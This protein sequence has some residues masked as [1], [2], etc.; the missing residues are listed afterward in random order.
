MALGAFLATTGRPAEARPENACQLLPVVLDV[1][2]SGTRYQTEISFTNPDREAQEMAVR[3]TASLGLVEGDGD[4]RFSV[5]PGGQLFVRDGIEFLRQLGVAIQ[6]STAGTPQAGTLRICSLNPGALPVGVMAR[7]TSPTRPPFAAGKAGVAFAAVPA[8][9]GFAGRAIVFGFR[10]NA[11]ERSNVAIYNPGAEPV[12][13]SVTL[14]SGSGERRSVISAKEDL[15]GYAWKQFTN[16]S[17]GTPVIDQGYVV[18][19]RIS[20]GGFFGAY[21]VVNDNDTN[22]GSFIPAAAEGELRTSWTIPVLVDSPSYRSELILANP[23]DVDATFSLV[24]MDSVTRS[25]LPRSA[26]VPVAA[27]RQVIVPDVFDLF[28]AGPL[29][30]GTVTSAGTLRVRTLEEEIRGAFVG[31]RVLTREEGGRFGVFAP[32][33]PPESA[34]AD[35]GFLWGLRADADTR[36]NVAVLNASS[37]SGE[38]ITLQ[39]QVF[40]GATGRPAGAPLAVTLAPGQWAQPEG[41]FASSGA[42]NGDVRIVRV[43]GSGPWSAYGVVNDGAAPG[44]GTGDG[45]FVP[46]VFF[47]GAPNRLPEGAWGAEGVRMWVDATGVNIE[48]DCSHGSLLGP[49]FLDAQGRFSG[50]GTYALEGGPTPVGGFPA[51]NVLYS[52]QVERGQMTLTIS[53][54]LLPVSAQMRLVAIQGVSPQLHK[55]L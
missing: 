36:S 29:P 16:P 20:A 6:G 49:V 48:T 4:G 35:Q 23:G 53:F 33:V 15:A 10:R 9:E 44:E 5:P 43:S 25:G 13:V 17:V 51:H 27:H 39:L 54:P 30:G 3:Y 31:V 8:D 2:A 12:S 52:G 19:E 42:A 11:L 14:V 18:V 28:Q 21:G 26:I 34:D 37:S 24:Y 1:E 45:S 41:F 40:D 32:A 55:C 7:I 22:D 38:S 50:A 46:V 47:V